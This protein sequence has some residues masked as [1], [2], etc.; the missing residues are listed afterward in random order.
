M[1]PEA[2]AAL[3][4]YRWPGNVRELDNVIQR[5]CLACDG[6]ELGAPPTARRSGAEPR[7]EARSPAP[8]AVLPRARAPPRP[9][10]LASAVPVCASQRM[11][12]LREIESTAVRVG[13]LACGGNITAA[14]RMLGV[15]RT[16]LYRDMKKAR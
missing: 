1:R 15:S 9:L 3:A 16:K 13:A 8:R 6:R 4:E 14:A 12:T 2:L 11:R 10:G 7:R 5:A